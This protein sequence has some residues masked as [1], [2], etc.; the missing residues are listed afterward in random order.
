MTEPSLDAL[1][2]EVDRIDD[3]LIDLLRERMAVVA[4]I[5]ATKGDRERGRLAL[6]PAR[7]AA[8]LRRLVERARPDG[9]PAVTI[10]RMWRELLAATARA[11]T[12]FAVSCAGVGAERLAREQFGAVVPVLPLADAAAAVAAVLDGRVRLAVATARDIAAMELPRG[13]RVVIC[14]PFCPPPGESVAEPALVVGDLP[15]EDSGDDLTLIRISA[16]LAVL[17]EA[18]AERLGGRLLARAAAGTSAHLLVEAAGPIG[19]ERL[20]A[21]AGE[22]PAAADL[23]LVILGSYP[24]PMS[25]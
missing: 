22:G 5:A 12:P 14:L 6:R 25:G 24:R 15:A 10:V 13:L 4:R 8:I 17:A 9:P 16:P 7:E 3:A 11:Q 21:A 1:R 18:A 23:R 20:A 19:A 2:R